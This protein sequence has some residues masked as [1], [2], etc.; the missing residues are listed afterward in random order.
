MDMV[1]FHKSVYIVVCSSVKC[2]QPI[3][4]YASR[5]SMK[6]D[7]S[8]IVVISMYYFDITIFTKSMDKNMFSYSNGKFYYH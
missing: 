2:F 7:L 4:S 1:P 3:D 8:Y 5:G 6:H